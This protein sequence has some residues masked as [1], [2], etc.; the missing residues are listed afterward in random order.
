MAFGSGVNQAI[1]EVATWSVAICICSAGVAYHKDLAKGLSGVIQYA[2]DQYKG[3][4]V[5]VPEKSTGFDRKIVIP[6]NTYG[7]YHVQ[8]RINGHNAKL[9]AD[10][11]ATL[12]ALT[13]ETA[14]QLGI[15]PNSLRFNGR[16]RTANGIARVAH[17]TLDRIEIGDIS[18]KNVPAFIAEPG[19]L[20]INLLGMSFIG[21]LQ[22]VEMK[23]GNLILTQ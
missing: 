15:N 6:S 17:V 21:K 20:T 23:D 16:T 3:T 1:K 4:L 19:K 5:S 9:L 10:T 22:H 11:G 8:A 14:E 18:V 12:V 2:E 7:H 13:H